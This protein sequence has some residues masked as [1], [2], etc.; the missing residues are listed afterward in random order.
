MG[1]KTVESAV[2]VIPPRDIWGPIE[3]LRRRFDRHQARWMPHL[4]LLYPFRPREEFPEAE[5]LALQ[6]C[7]TQSAF[8]VTLGD[9]RVFEG[10]GRTATLW[11]APDPA[12]P[13]LDLQAALQRAFPDCDDVA[14][15]PEGYTPHL[16]LGQAYDPRQLDERL[17]QIREVWRP[18]SFQVREI[19]LLARSGDSPFAVL[20]T[21]RLGTQA[22]SM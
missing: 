4:A 14:R 16:C 3:V 6:A 5:A 7:A 11:A 1:A 12:R 18:L 13:M 22:I 10:V 20:R 19:S 15:Q 9:L 21:V 8:T 17:G 2:V